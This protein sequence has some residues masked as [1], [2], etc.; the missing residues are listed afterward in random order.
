VIRAPRAP[1]EAEL[2]V[3]RASN[4]GV[5]NSAHQLLDPDSKEEL[6][7]I[8]VAD[9]AD[10]MGHYDRWELRAAAGGK[11]VDWSQFKRGLF[12]SGSKFRDEQFFELYGAVAEE[13]LRV[14]KPEVVRSEKLHGDRGHVSSSSFP[15]PVRA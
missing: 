11:S 5:V 3:T 10:V 8:V 4:D 14:I 13:L 15:P 9:H 12:R 1:S 7:G 6:A 2:L